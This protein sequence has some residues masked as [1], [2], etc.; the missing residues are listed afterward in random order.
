M[1]GNFFGLICRMEDCALVEVFEYLFYSVFLLTEDSAS[2]PFLLNR[3]TSPVFV[4][5]TF[6]PI[7]HRTHVDTQLH[8]YLF[9]QRYKLFS[10][11]Q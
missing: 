6:S 9:S 10:S 2:F 5:E 3:C 1:S 8:L 7:W 11:T 4:P